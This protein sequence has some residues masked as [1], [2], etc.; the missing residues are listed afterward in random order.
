MQIYRGF[1][2]FLTLLLASACLGHPKQ[3]RTL[4]P[5]QYTITNTR[6]PQ[7]AKQCSAT[8]REALYQKYWG[9]GKAPYMSEFETYFSLD[10]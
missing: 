5:T 1:L 9:Q 3:P 10:E 4:Q 6:S 7:L 2:L 8:N